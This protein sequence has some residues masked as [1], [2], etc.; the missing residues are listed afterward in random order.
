MLREVEPITSQLPSGCETEHRA[1]TGFL[2]RTFQF[3]PV[4]SLRIKYRSSILRDRNSHHDLD[5]DERRKVSRLEQVSFDADAATA[6]DDVSLQL[7]RHSLLRDEHCKQRRSTRDVTRAERV[8]AS[9]HL[10][11]GRRPS[12]RVA[13]CRGASAS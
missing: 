1:A 4:T 2:S 6:A 3:Q 11:C 7:V 9:S 12:R 8:A 10:R 5:C 13:Q